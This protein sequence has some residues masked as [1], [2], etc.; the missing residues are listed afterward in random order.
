VTGLKKIV[1]KFTAFA[2]VSLALF[3][4]LLNTMLN[5]VPGKTNA[6]SAEFT[7]VSGLRV[8]DDVRVAGVRVGRVQ[9]IAVSGEGARVDFDVVKDQPVLS[10]TGLVMRYQNLIG[11]RYLALVQPAQ[12]GTELPSGTDIP[13]AR[14]DAGFDLTSLLNGFR[15]LFETLNPA[16]VN[17]L[18]TSLIKVL[19]GEGPTV[20]QLLKQTSQLT[21]YVADRDKIFGEVV[22]NLTPVLND[23][24]GQGTELTATVKEL[25]ALMAGLA[26]D[27]KAIGQ[28]IDGVSRLIVSTSDLL[29]QARGPVTQASHDFRT[30][31]AL[32]AQNRQKIVASLHAFGNI[33]ELLGRAGS[34]ENAL[35]VYAC[36]LWFQASGQKV[37]TA[38]GD[39]GPWSEVCR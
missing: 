28:S 2:V 39:G 31:A 25:R 1:A 30:T 5:G 26:K 29:Q 27:R 33:F 9:R 18:A 7:D 23:I 8:G 22:T 32:L 6:Y 38:G 20:E 34:Y 21:N 37:N 12:R 16:D 15:P 3:V 36:T 13:V 17:Q 24:A 14:T 11:Q 4:L 19:Q 10:N 35:N